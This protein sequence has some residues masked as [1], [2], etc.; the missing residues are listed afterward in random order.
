MSNVASVV[1]RAVIRCSLLPLSSNSDIDDDD[2]DDDDDG[3]Q[4]KLVRT[5]TIGRGRCGGC[6]GGG[7]C[8]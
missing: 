4:S 7:G 5:V 8:C 3:I 1:L 2:D 6:C